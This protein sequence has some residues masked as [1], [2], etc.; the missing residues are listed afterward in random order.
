MAVCAAAGTRA[1]WAQTAPAA[2]V[3]AGSQSGGE[4]GGET[5][6]ATGGAIGSASPPPPITAP[7][8]VLPLAGFASGDTGS[9]TSVRPGYLGTALESQV[10]QSFVPQSGAPAGPL[11][12]KWQIT[13]ALG[14]TE[15][16]TDNAQATGGTSTQGDLITIVQPSLAIIG[17]TPRLQVNLS[18][19]PQIYLYARDSSQSRVAQ[20]FNA[21]ALATL[22]PETL[23]LDLRG[24]GAEQALFGG[25][26]P[27][28]SATPSSDQ[29]SQDYSFSITPYL[30]HRFGTA[31]TGELGYTYARTV[32]T[33][34]GT[35]SALPLFTAFPQLAP[36]TNQ[37][38]TTQ[39]FHAAFVTGEAFGRYNATALASVTDYT[40]SGVL[41]DAHR[42]VFFV[43]NGYA[44]TRTIT[45]LGTI[46]YENISY[47]GTQPLHIS[48]AIWNLGVRLL[49][50]ADSTITLRYGHQDGLNALT[51]DAA[52]SP[53][54]RTLLYVRYSKG[55]TTSQE[56]LQNALAT[57]DLDALGNP[58]DHSTGAPI[59]AASNFFGTQDTLSILSRLSVS[60]AYRLDRDTVTATVER[61]N[62]D[63]I[64]A[65]IA[66]TGTPLGSNT[67]VY[68]SLAWVHL[69]SP[70]LTSAAFFQYGVRT[71]TGAPSIT[72][73]T[74]TASLSLA[75]ALG[76]TLNT[77]VQYT[78]D[79]SNGGGGL[80]GVAGANTRDNILM[81]SL[82]KTF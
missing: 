4:T 81:L 24:F 63:V 68:G 61:D 18:Y 55:L 64:S 54:P 44:I 60:G 66:A 27:A 76:P 10:A 33:A 6:G 37:N 70:R 52:L 79:Q 34:T 39:N 3:G 69:L 78:H 43:D 77:T 1:A 49:P 75:Y 12:P 25:L 53:T 28:S 72:Q 30:L 40:G 7:P 80:G 11:P 58:I 2:S 36:P 48:D 73:N 65:P 35:P 71:L 82:I 8:T 62:Y 14:I 20:N 21:R 29:S 67:G 41:S 47:A 9:G 26:P 17:D 31:G 23:F 46:G 32:Q 51:V 15:E 19:A 22:V 16:L 5:G 56:Q 59:F 74:L 45:A 42:D 13:P 38:T 57:T 50:N